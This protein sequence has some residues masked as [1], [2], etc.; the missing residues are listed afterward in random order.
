ML[1]VFA[2]VGMVNA[3]TFETTLWEGTYSEAIELNSEKVATFKA[4]NVLRVYVTVPS[5]G[6]NF[7]LC[8]KGSATGWSETAIPS[9]NNNQWPWVNEG[10]EYY[11]VTFTDADITALSGQNIYIEKGTNENSTI[12]KV[13]LTGEVAAS[14]ET[15]LLGTP[16]EGSWTQMNFDAQSGAKIGDVLRLNYTCT[17]GDYV[18]INFFDA[19]GNNTF[20]GTTIYGANAP[21]STGIFDYEITSYDDLVKIQTAGFAVKGEKFT[22]TSLKLLTYADSYDAVSVTIESDG[23][24][25]WSHEKN[26]DFTDTGITAYYASKVTTGTVTLTSTATTWNYCGYI[27]KGPEGTYIVKAV[28]DEDASYPKALYLKAQTSEG[29]VAKSTVNTYHYIFAKSKTDG[30]GFYKLTED[31]TLAAHKA[32]LETETDITPSTPSGSALTRGIIL[33]FGDGTTAILNVIDDG[34]ARQISKNDGKYYTLQ[35]TSMQAPTRK[36]LYILNG[37]KVLVK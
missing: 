18:Q 8:Y 31:H 26:L 22:L 21:A 5:G 1:A 10:S 11:D 7:K 24:A 2:M 25:T 32:Y 29:T 36:G 4:G 33:D 27:L 28:A 16:W 23:I 15:E 19:S 14:A 30:I 13:V 3:K 6:A 34:D 17:Q 20:T 12:T 9:M 37:K 35:G